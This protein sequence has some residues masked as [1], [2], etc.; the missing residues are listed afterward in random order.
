M[1]ETLD[2][3]M[4]EINQL[5]TTHDY[6]LVVVQDIWLRL[7]GN[8]CVGYANQQLRYLENVKKYKLSKEC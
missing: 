2:E 7:Q 3:V 8:Q 5:V 1:A 6:P 4:Q